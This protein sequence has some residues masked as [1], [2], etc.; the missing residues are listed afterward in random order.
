MPVKALAWCKAHYPN[1]FELALS[2]LFGILIEIVILLFQ[3]PLLMVRRVGDD[4]ADQMIRL[5][6]RTTSTIPKSPAFVF[7]DIDDATWKSWG[8]P[9]VTPR[10][11]IATLLARVA[12]SKPLAIALDVDLAYPDGT[13]G[14]AL[15]DFLED[16]KPEW[17][18]LLLV[19]SL[20]ND[21]DGGLPRPR[22]TDYDGAIGQRTVNGELV[23][24]KDNV[25][26][27][28]PLFERDADGKVRRW[29]LFA[30]ACDG[31]AP[32]VV[33]SMHLAA[34]MIA[35]Q[36]IYGAPPGDEVLPLKRMTGSLAPFTPANCQPVSGGHKG[37]LELVAARSP[38]RDRK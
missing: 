12:R 30:E 13:D 37:P 29:K 17:P 33:P 15:K 32:I 25:M 22:V 19:R 6:E 18:P 24:A 34:A 20:A 23:P 36:A 10:A 9:L 16:Y 35:R 1:S 38:D 8:S 27:T 4:T 5:L 3:P 21:P 14:K 2:V 28:S 31:G 11:H 26:F 7:I